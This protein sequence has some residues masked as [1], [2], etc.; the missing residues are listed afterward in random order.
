[1]INFEWIQTVELP[2]LRRLVQLEREAFGVGG[3]NEWH[4]VPFIRHGRVYAIRK[5]EDVVGSVQ[6]MLDWDSPCKAYMVGVS[7]AKEVRGQG[8]GTELIKKSLQALANENIDEV[9]LTV[10]AANVAAIRVYEGKLGFLAKMIRKDEYGEG[11]NRLVMTLSL[12]DFTGKIN[13]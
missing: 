8:L 4:L 9:E 3:L 6:Y 13:A 2:L 10:D 11:E 1:M 7:V 12:G 5:N